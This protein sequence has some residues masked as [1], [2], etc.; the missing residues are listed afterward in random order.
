MFAQGDNQNEH[1][2]YRGMFKLNKDYWPKYNIAS[3]TD[4]S[5]HVH[6]EKSFNDA[7]FLCTNSCTDY[8]ECLTV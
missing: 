3:S 6:A 8:F 4:V 5:R 7:R 1:P 2:V